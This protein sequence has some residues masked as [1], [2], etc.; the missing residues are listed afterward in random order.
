MN[1]KMNDKKER[2]KNILRGLSQPDIRE[3]LAN[4]KDEL[5]QEWIK[6]LDS[7][8]EKDDPRSEA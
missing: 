3:I 8:F 2:I 6:D 1:L 7:C 5:E 4:V